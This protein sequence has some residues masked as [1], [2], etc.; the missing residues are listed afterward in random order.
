MIKIMLFECHGFLRKLREA[1]CW[2]FIV[3]GYH[4]AKIKEALLVERLKRYE[5]SRLQGPRV[6]SVEITGEERF[7]MK[8]MAQK[9]SN[10]IPVGRRVKVFCKPCKP[11]QIQEYANELA[12]LSG[13]I[14]IQIIGD[15]TII[16]YR[17]KDYVQPE[18][19]SPV[20]TLSKK[21]HVLDIYE[22]IEV[23]GILALFKLE[24]DGYNTKFIK[25]DT[26]IG[27][28]DTRASSRILIEIEGILNVTLRPFFLKNPVRL[29][30]Y[31]THNWACYS[32]P[33]THS[34]YLLDPNPLLHRRSKSLLRSGNF[35]YPLT[36]TQMCTAQIILLLMWL[37]GCH[38]FQ[39]TVSHIFCSTPFF[40][41]NILDKWVRCL[42]CSCSALGLLLLNRSGILFVYSFLISVWIVGDG[43]AV[44]VFRSV[45]MDGW[46]KSIKGQ[47]GRLLPWQPA[48]VAAIVCAPAFLP[49]FSDPWLYKM[50]TVGSFPARLTYILKPTRKGTLF[51]YSPLICVPR[52]SVMSLAVSDQASVLHIVAGDVHGNFL[53]LIDKTFG[54]ACFKFVGLQLPNSVISKRFITRAVVLHFN[55]HPR[56]FMATTMLLSNNNN[57]KAN[58]LHNQYRCI[59]VWPSVATPLT[60]WWSSQ[61]DFVLTYKHSFYSNNLRSCRRHGF[62]QVNGTSTNAYNEVM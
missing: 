10:D 58:Y 30:I 47:C 60:H 41:Y 44:C 17:G 50:E 15:D 19:M 55:D 46:V 56:V 5:V 57:R 33:L 36:S 11:G 20:D 51:W 61:P 39:S 24:L 22:P 9:G 35:T 29:E 45:E 21:K 7:Y 28:E 53:G 1:D 4:K 8:K 2:V 49:N 62:Q 43:L 59:P 16:F 14:P 27:H 23:V 12:R 54:H 18:V 42:D 52:V 31:P 38:L 26:G 34:L 6:K 25:T 48:T 32:S 3:N 13:G 37:D 40:L